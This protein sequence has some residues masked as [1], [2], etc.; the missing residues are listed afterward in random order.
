MF[1]LSRVRKLIIQTDFAFCFKAE[2]GVYG[3]LC[4]MHKGDGCAFFF[5]NSE[6]PRPFWHGRS[7]LA[8]KYREAT[9]RAELNQEYTI[10]EERRAGRCKNS[11]WL[12]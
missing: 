1:R 10:V 9:M 7:S 8:A 4:P 3:Y 11:I 12:T 5:L 6:I 2:E